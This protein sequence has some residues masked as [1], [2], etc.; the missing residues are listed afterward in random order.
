MNKLANLIGRNIDIVLL[1]KQTFGKSRWYND[2]VCLSVRPPVPTN[3]I[4][5]GGGILFIRLWVYCFFMCKFVS[6]LYIQI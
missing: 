4:W 1:V 6:F 2:A 3:E 5:E